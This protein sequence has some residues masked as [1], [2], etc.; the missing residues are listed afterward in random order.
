MSET[1]YSLEA[2]MREI[3]MR[4]R[5]AAQRAPRT[6]HPPKPRRHRLAEQLRSVA[7]RLE[8]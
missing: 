4:Q 6:P 3:E 5:A 7:D 1:L 2:R 8:A